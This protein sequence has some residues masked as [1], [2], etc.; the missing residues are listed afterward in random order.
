M[1]TLF[2]YYTGN[3]LCVTSRWTS[4]VYCSVCC[5]HAVVDPVSTNCWTVLLLLSMK[6]GGVCFEMACSE[7]GDKSLGLVVTLHIGWS[8][9]YK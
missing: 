2:S 9:D 3:E 7:K 1:H 4:V 8:I 5:A 6:R